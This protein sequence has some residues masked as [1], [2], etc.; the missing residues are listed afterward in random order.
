[1]AKLI[2]VK[3]ETHPTEENA[4]G[5]WAYFDGKPTKAECL[6]AWSNRG[7]NDFED[8]MADSGPRK[9]ENKADPK[10]HKKGTWRIWLGCYQ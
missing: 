6:K 8:T 4:C 9:S 5:W 3:V 1:M 10:V 7:D 2:A